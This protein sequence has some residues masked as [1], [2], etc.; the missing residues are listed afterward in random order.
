VKSGILILLLTLAVC[1]CRDHGDSETPPVEYRL[2]VGDTTITIPNAAVVFAN[3]QFSLD[4]YFLREY[5]VARDSIWEHPGAIFNGT[6][7]DWKALVWSVR[8][9]FL[10]APYSRDVKIANDAQYYYMI[11]TYLDQ[12][13]YGWRDT[14]DPEADLFNPAVHIWLHPADTTLVPDNTATVQFDG[15]SHLVEQY[16]ALWRFE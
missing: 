9:T 14:F 12:F 1:S 5:Q 10:L 3:A 15:T 11:G 16:R 4:A 6:L 2:T 7:I 13:G 8:Q